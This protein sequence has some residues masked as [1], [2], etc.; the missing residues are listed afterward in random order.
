MP[1]TSYAT[2]QS[3]VALF[4]NRSDLTA[5]IPTFIQ[6][7]EADFNRR[8]RHWRQETRATLTLSGEYVALPTDWL[9][10][11]RLDLDTATGARRIA[12][13]SQSFIQSK[14]TYAGEPQ[15]YAMATDGLRFWPVP[16]SGTADLLYFAKIPALSDSATTNWLLTAAPDVY[17]YGS[18]IHSAPYLGE[19]ERV[20]AWGSLYEA[21]IERLQS[22]SD[23]SR[24]SSGMRLA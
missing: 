12:P 19:D 17:L 18:L 9:E 3:E 2:L 21:A 22:D 7:A 1:I 8:L 10:T 13:V 24:W 16:S 23:K 6:M 20:G 4:L 11:I 14:Q 15:Y 5:I